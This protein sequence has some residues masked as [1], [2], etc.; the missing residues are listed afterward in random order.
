M[1]RIDILVVDFIPEGLEF[2]LV[3]VVVELVLEGSG[4]IGILY[5]VLQLDGFIE[6]RAD[7]FMHFVCDGSNARE[8][9]H[10]LAGV[11]VF[12]VLLG[13]LQIVVHV[14]IAH[15]VAGNHHSILLVDCVRL[16]IL[17]NHLASEV[18]DRCLA[19]ALSESLTG[20][21][22]EAFYTV[23]I[24]LV[25]DNS[26]SVDFLYRLLAQLFHIHAIAI[27]VYTDTQATTDLLTLSDCRRGMTQRTDLE[28]IWIIPPFPKGRV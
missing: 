20:L 15:Q 16:A 24:G 6:E 28:D 2:L 27:L 7:E 23:G 10:E 25:G 26:K 1:D 12:L 11:T 19:R 5:H 14:S 3:E 8:K 21:V 18:F 22:L 9:R 4:F 17:L 13:N